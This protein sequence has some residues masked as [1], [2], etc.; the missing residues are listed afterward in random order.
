M[1]VSRASTKLSLA[2]TALALAAVTGCADVGSSTPSAD[3]EFPVAKSTDTNVIICESI[4]QTMQ[5]DKKAAEEARAAGN[6][7]EAAAKLEAVQA[8][9][10]GAA[11]VPGCD[12]S[13][14]VSGAPSAP[15]PAVSP[16]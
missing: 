1:T 8:G 11:T 4:K 5:K 15:S 13:D 14:L 6:T 3:E 7:R 16:S 9:A 2:L 10:N 12:I